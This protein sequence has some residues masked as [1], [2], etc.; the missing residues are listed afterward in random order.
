MRLGLRNP[1]KRDNMTGDCGAARILQIPA[2]R[3]LGCILNALGEVNWI[4]L[5]EILPMIPGRV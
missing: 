5:A 1:V 4:L 2:N 3:I